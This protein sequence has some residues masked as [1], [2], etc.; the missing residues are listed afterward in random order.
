MVSAFLT[1]SLASLALGQVNVPSGFTP[2]VKWQIEIQ[3]PLAT[4][5]TLQPSDALVWDIDLY[6]AASNPR[7]IPYIR[8][9]IPGAIVICYF[10]AGLVQQTDCDY[11]SDWANSGLLGRG[12]P[13]FP[14]ESFIDVRNP[15]AVELIQ[16]RITLANQIGCDGVDPDNI[17]T[18]IYDQDG[19]TGVS[20]YF[21]YHFCR[22][23]NPHTNHLVFSMF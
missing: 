11:D 8:S 10:N 17:D 4:S 20:Y 23:N 12:H 16:R 14:E 3:T 2:G 1:L 9:Q 5:G 19:S 13:D 7:I 18:Y 15:R 22:L 6:Q 21:P